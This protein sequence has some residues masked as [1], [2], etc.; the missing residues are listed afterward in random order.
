MRAINTQHLD[1][2][3]NI[4]SLEGGGW[5]EQA[6]TEGKGINN[7]GRKEN[8]EERI[9]NKSWSFTKYKV[10]WFKFYMKI[11]VNSPSKEIQQHGLE[12]KKSV[13]FKLFI[14]WLLQCCITVFIVK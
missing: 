5:S 6:Q 10:N 1:A 11:T 14:T 7:K 9:K 8:E 13:A 4:C 2:G 3:T 12:E